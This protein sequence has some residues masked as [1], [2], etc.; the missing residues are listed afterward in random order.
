MVERRW[1]GCN[2]SVKKE[3]NRWVYKLDVDDDS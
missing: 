3:L 2:F 1:D